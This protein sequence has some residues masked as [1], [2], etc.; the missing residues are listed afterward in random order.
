MDWNI[1]AA[2]YDS[3]YANRFVWSFSVYQCYL[4]VNAPALKRNEED[5][6][7]NFAVFYFYHLAQINFVTDCLN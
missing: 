1:D 3:L 5:Q 2:M 6:E 4:N 7:P